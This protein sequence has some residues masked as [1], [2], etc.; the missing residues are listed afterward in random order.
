MLVSVKDEIDTS[1]DRVEIWRDGRNVTDGLGLVRVR[2]G[3]RRTTYKAVWPDRRP[4]RVNVRFIDDDGHG[5]VDGWMD[6]VP[7]DHARP[8]VLQWPVVRWS[9]GNNKKD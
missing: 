5:G 1:G 6:Y 2:H 8:D 9:T 3:D 4:C 7:F